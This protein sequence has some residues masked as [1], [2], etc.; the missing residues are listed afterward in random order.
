MCLET[1]IINLNQLFRSHRFSR[2]NDTMQSLL[3]VVAVLAAP[4]IAL[5]ACTREDLL[6]NANKYVAAQSIGKV[7]G[8]SGNFSYR[9]NNN[10]INISAGVLSQAM[11][12]DYNR[13][14]ADTTA[15]ASYS[16]IVS[17]T[18]PKPYV[19]S[20]QIRYNGND[21]SAITLIDT[22]AATT[23]S[24]F[25]NAT[26]TLKYVQQESWESIAP[27][28]QASRDTLKAIGDAYLDMWNN[29]TAADSI[30]WGAD[31]ERVEGSEYNKPCGSAL[32]HGGSTQGNTMRRYVIDETLGSVD[33]LCEFDAVSPLKLADSHEIRIDAGK[34]KYVLTVDV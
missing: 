7:D 15:C 5:A 33:V 20:T 30:P 19:I 18:G 10:V 3:G 11:K 21:T 31:C 29:A 23:G 4:A 16:M 6:A 24:L 2:K 12:I 22:V 32:P 17:A 9:E 26:A 1:I 27:A 14:T 8:L 28:N 13:S 34:V 25:F